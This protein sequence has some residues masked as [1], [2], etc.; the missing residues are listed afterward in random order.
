M[1]SWCYRSAARGRRPCRRASR[2]KSRRASPGCPVDPGAGSGASPATRAAPGASPAARRRPGRKTRSSPRSR[3]TARRG[4]LGYRLCRSKSHCVFNTV[5]LPISSLLSAQAYARPAA[6]RRIADCLTKKSCGSGPSSRAAEPSF[7]AHA[8]AK[9]PRRAKLTR[10]RGAPSTSLSAKETTVSS[11]T[12]SPTGERL[13]KT[14]SLRFY[15]RR[16]RAGNKNE[17][18]R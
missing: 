7:L 1:G 13:G 17:T 8:G 15:R 2:E 5:P 18:A 3:R 9:L 11:G 4:R 16:R 6:G 12:S 10:G 14:H